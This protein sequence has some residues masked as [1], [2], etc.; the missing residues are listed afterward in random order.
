M[1]PIVVAIQGECEFYHQGMEKKASGTVAGIFPIKAVAGNR[2]PESHFRGRMHAQLVGAAGNRDERYAA[3]A[4]RSVDEFIVGH[5]FFAAV[6]VYSLARAVKPIR[7]EW[8]VDSSFTRD[9]A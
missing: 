2:H 6:E 3:P 8:Q 9:A 7:R 1:E 5:C 4:F